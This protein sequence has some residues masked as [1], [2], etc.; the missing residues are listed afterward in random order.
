MAERR[1][2]G[3]WVLGLVFLALFATGVAMTRMKLKPRRAAATS[4]AVVD[5]KTP[6]SKLAELIRTGDAKALAVLYERVMARPDG[7]A[8]GLSL[9]EG[10]DWITALQALRTGYTKFSAYGRAS[11]M[12]ATGRI[13]NKFSIEQAPACWVDTLPPSHDVLTAGLSD[14]EMNVRLA[15]M[16]QTRGVW[17]WLPGCSTYAAEDEALAAWKEAFLAPV[18][19]RLAEPQPIMRAA[20]IACLGALPI[21]SAAAPA[22]AYIA[23]PSV[24]VRAQVVNAFA[25]RPGLLTEEMLLQR[26][27]DPDPRIRPMVERVLA[28]RGLSKE[29]IGLGALIMHPKAELR[30][31]V[32]PMLTNRTDIDPVAW[33]VRLSRDPEESV[34][35]KAAEALSTRATPEARQRLAEMAL[36]DPSPSVKKMAGKLVMPGEET[37][38]L[39]P[40]PG[41]PSL[42][43]K[44][45]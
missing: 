14:S 12:T 19:R 1:R 15:A 26:I 8:R 38:S 7:L 41:S 22:V 37:A 21:D 39:P 5:A 20:A 30:E 40:L 6:L 45:N 17:A 3:L 11:I 27:S 10:R 28:G 32:I 18:V 35:K 44:A 25:G 36:S 23:D 24:D 2:T 42:T 4:G 16:E 13:L 34:R 43:P 9:T 33:L 29:L 31:S